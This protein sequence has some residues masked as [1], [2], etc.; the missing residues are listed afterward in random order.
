L[1]VEAVV[2]VVVVAEE[3]GRVGAARARFEVE[4]RKRRRARKRWRRWVRLKLKLRREVVRDMV[5]VCLSAFLF[6][7]ARWI[8]TLD[9]CEFSYEERKKSGR[10]W[11]FLGD[12]HRC[13]EG[14]SMFCLLYHSRNTSDR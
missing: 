6:F 13:C 14:E 8:F 4:E 12:C 5:V 3:E 7:R 2:F 9:V 10:D 1:D 11:K